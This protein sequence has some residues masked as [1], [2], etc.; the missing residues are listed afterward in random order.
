MD[1]ISSSVSG[2]SRTPIELRL[3]RLRKNPESFRVLRNEEGTVVGYASIYSMRKETIERFIRDEIRTSDLTEE[4]ILPFE[5]GHP[6]HIYLMALCVTPDCTHQ[7]KRI[8]GLRLILGLMAF[9]LELASRG[10]EV[11]TITARTWT[12]DGLRLL[13]HMNI[14]QVRSPVPGKNLFSVQVA[15]SGI[16]LL[17]RYSEALEEWKNLHT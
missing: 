10:V 4:E 17:I 1:Y 3:A 14:P 15:E 7:Q 11:E 2:P 9:L 5:P 8:Y 16:P 13:R 12:S 6:T